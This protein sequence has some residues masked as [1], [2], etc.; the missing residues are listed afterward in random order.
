M[1]VRSSGNSA[2]Q[3]TVLLLA[4]VTLVVVLMAATAHFAGRLVTREHAQ[5]AADAAAL[6]GTVGGRPA[7]TALANAN[8]GELLSF[9]LL[10]DVVQVVVQVDDATATA[11]ATRAP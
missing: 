8:G 4:V 6:A 9:A 2:G 1:R 7:A 3:A 11:R 5:I 10:G